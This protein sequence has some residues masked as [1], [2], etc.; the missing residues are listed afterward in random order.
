[1]L[2][3][4]FGCYAE[5]HTPTIVLHFFFV[6]EV[7]MDWKL[8]S[9]NFQYKECRKPGWKVHVTSKV[10]KTCFVYWFGHLEKS[11]CLMGPLELNLRWD[12]PT[13]NIHM[14]RF[15]KALIT[16]KFVE[17]LGLVESW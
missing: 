10:T 6:E 8:R 3:A 9:M 1:M 5:I 13:I 2:Y 15:I 7:K 4:E 14:V 16:R 12:Y 17:S 11:S